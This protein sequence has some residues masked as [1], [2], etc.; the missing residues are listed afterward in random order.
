MNVE[1][2]DLIYIVVRCN[3]LFYRDGL[4]AQLMFNGGGLSLWREKHV[5]SNVD[6]FSTFV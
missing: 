1:I 6:L 4:R 2:Y 3:S 5:S